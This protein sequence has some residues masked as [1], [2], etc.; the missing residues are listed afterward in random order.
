V[1]APNEHHRTPTQHIAELAHTLAERRSAGGTYVNIKV[2]AQGSLQPDV[3]VTP[4][5]DEEELRRMTAM[6]LDS[7]AE[8]MAH[9]TA[10]PVPN[11]VAVAKSAARKASS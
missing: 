6:A 8:I 10:K 1:T 4:D 5:T 3:N 9:S 2:S 11:P 7:V